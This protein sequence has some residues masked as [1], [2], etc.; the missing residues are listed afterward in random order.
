M[1]KQCLNCKKDVS[2]FAVKCPNCGAQ[3]NVVYVSEE[4]HTSRQVCTRKKRDYVFVVSFVML[5]ISVIYFFTLNTLLFG[6]VS[7]LKAIYI[8]SAAFA[9]FWIF[10]NKLLDL[11]K[12]KGKNIA[13]ALGGIIILAAL[14]I[15][16]RLAYYKIILGVIAYE[17]ILSSIF[18]ASS[19]ISFALWAICV[20]L[21]IF[22]L[23]YLIRRK[24]NNLE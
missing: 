4:L 23:R 15:V 17:Y 14:R 8:C 20:E 11:R 7:D 3:L 19:F 13:I 18:R 24:K 6:M 2:E 22:E 9:L 21:F 10:K 12:L 5:I 1:T 16:M